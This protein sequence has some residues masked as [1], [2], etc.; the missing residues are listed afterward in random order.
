MRTSARPGKKPSVVTAVRMECTGMSSTPT[1]TKDTLNSLPGT[2]LM[3][4]L[5]SLLQSGVPFLQKHTLRGWE[6]ILPLI[7]TGVKVDTL[8][9]NWKP[10]DCKYLLLHSAP[11]H[12]QKLLNWYHCS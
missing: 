12:P 9:R 4:L 1:M 2:I 11:S 8:L 3:S 10:F 5:L 7:Q 6:E